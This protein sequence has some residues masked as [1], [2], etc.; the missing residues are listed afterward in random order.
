[1]AV[2]KTEKRRN[3]ILAIVSR[4]EANVE[5]LSR[6][7]NVSESTIR[8][9]LA[10]LANSGRILRTYGGAALSLAHRPESTMDERLTANRAQKEAIARLAATRV[11][12][13][14]TL[15]LDVG[16]TTAALA[17]QLNGHGQ[18][19][20]ITNN[21]TAL[22][23]LAQDPRIALTVLGGTLRKM[24]MGTVGPLA[25]LAL[26]RITAD[27]VFLGADGLVAGRGLCEATLDQAA[28]KGKM[29]DQAAEVF[30]LADASKLGFAGQQAWTPLDR[31]WTLITDAG[32]TRAQLE[33][34]EA[35][36]N[37]SILIAEVASRF[38]SEATSEL[39]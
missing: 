22:A 19:H 7:F 28:L 21:L 3:A 34:F 39:A 26:S 1:M 27:K 18:L 9:D 29:I 14:D 17:A 33:P 4:E 11:S 31:R 25:E 32:A 35:L 16:T 23:T 8:R 6:H 38:A 2:T 13:G 36:P 10:E 37:V 15:I 20:V 12:D 5:A 24:S 30:V